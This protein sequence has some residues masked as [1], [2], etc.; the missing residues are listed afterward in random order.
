[1]SGELEIVKKTVEFTYCV[2]QVDQN[3]VVLASWGRKLA[4]VFTSLLDSRIHFDSSFAKINPNGNQNVVYMQH[5]SFI[6]IRMIDEIFIIKNCNVW[7][8]IID[9]PLQTLF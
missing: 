3:T 4:T 1:M 7:L 9:S 2:F 6:H 5:V 8:K